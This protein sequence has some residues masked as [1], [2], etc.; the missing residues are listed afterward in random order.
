MA[1][2]EHLLTALTRL[3]LFESGVITA[4]CLN[5]LEKLPKL[6]AFDHLFK[7]DEMLHDTPP[8]LIA[9]TATSLLLEPDSNF[10]A[11]TRLVAL[12]T[13]VI[14]PSPCPAA[15]PALLIPTLKTV[16]LGQSDSRV[17]ASEGLLLASYVLQVQPCISTLLLYLDLPDDEIVI[18]AMPQRFIELI[19]TAQRRSNLKTLYV[20]TDIAFA[21]ANRVYNIPALRHGWLKVSFVDE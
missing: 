2:P 11:W 17:P 10:D 21:H 9:R 20:N 6:R 18:D 7:P 15:P 3:D 1:V 19:E 14:I 12:E 4:A 16:A 8:N 5:R 13:L